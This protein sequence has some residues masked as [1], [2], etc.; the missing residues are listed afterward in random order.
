MK[1]LGAF[2]AIVLAA[3]G[4]SG[5]SS[6]SGFGLTQRQE[7]GDLGFPTGLAQPGPVDAVNAFP[8]LSFARPVKITHAGD[9]SD[10]LFVVEQDGVIRVFQNNP[11]VTSSAVWL[12][13]RPLVSRAGNEEGLL[14]LAFDPD[15]SNNGYFY[16]YYS[17]AGPRRSVIARYTSSSGIVDA[18]SRLALLSFSQPFGN[19]NGG[20]LLF[21]ADGK[22]YVSSG[23]GGSGGDP[24][25]NGQSLDTFLGKILRMNTDGTAPADNPFH[26]GTGG[27]RDYVWAY[28]LRNPWR[29]SFDR[30]TGDLW[31]GDVG[32]G[33]REEI[34]LI[35]RGGNYG[36]RLFEG[37]LTFNNPGNLPYD[38]YEPPVVDYGR[39][40]GAS[41]TGGYVYRGAA[42]PSLAGAYFYADF[43]SGRVWALV[44]N[45]DDVVSNEQVVSVTNPSSFGE[46]E[47]GEMYVCS[48]D[49]NIYRFEETGPADEDP[50][51][52]LSASGLF[53]DLA[54]LDPARGL[55]E[56]GVN[57]ELWADGATKRR[58]IAVPGS[59]RILFDA[60]GAWGFPVGTVIVK[61]FELEG[62]RVETRVLV[63]ALS[64]WQGYAYRWN[65]AGTDADLDEDGETFDVPVAGGTQEWTIP[66]S[67]DCMVCH[68][69]AA[70]F[71]LGVRTHQLNREFDYPA[72]TDNQLRA[73]NHIE[74]FDRDIGDAG[75]YGALAEPFGAAGLDA[76]ARGYLDANCASCHRPGGPT[77]VNMD[78]RAGTA[79]GSMNVFDVV[80]SA[81]SI[82]TAEERRVVAGAKESSTLWDRMRRRD[83]LGMPPIASHLVDE[84]AVDLI[85]AWID[86]R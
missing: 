67:N 17:A 72:R 7:P 60:N 55:I 21:G 78:L 30:D 6:G 29:M 20:E 76:R 32:Q 75:Q 81:G 46:D 24:Q 84:E 54:T 62:T 53:D 25:N 28:G 34:D 79:E 69:A 9:G 52:T 35:V 49:G 58:W 66:S 4:G 1:F 16:V 57:A 5:G 2:F 23:D 74:L 65:A 45:G 86:S 11:A 48:F 12:D 85:G 36:W 37:R 14:G 3:C 39:G 8:Q 15:F 19:H 71:V 22:L 70:G 44:R 10:R 82:G 47:A 77:A 26:T 38:D 63:H 31:A 59:S 64:G 51:A 18:G 42:N 50:P 43:V 61:H 73:W 83:A 27:P 33:A 56:Y 40:L 68:N 80:P 41:V 13:I